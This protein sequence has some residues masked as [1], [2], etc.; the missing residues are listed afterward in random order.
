LNLA[1]EHKKYNKIEN[2][3]IKDA[4]VD[5]VF[6][7][8]IKASATLDYNKKLSVIKPSIFMILL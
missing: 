4:R 3:R 1:I 6:A 2:Y 7:T 8:L 5:R